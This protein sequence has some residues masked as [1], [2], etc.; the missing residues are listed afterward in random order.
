MKKAEKNLYD[1]LKRHREGEHQHQQ[2]VRPYCWF[3]DFVRLADSCQ[4]IAR[5]EVL[6]DGKRQKIFGSQLVCG[7]IIHLEHADYKIDANDDVK[8]LAQI[9]QELTIA[10]AQRRQNTVLRDLEVIK[11]A[12]P[13]DCLVLEGE[14]FIDLVHI[15][16]ESGVWKRSRRTL[17]NVVATAVLMPRSN[18]WCLVV[19]VGAS[20]SQGMLLKLEEVIRSNH[21][22]IKC[23][24]CYC[25]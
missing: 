10:D 20:S 15:T 3:T 1:H 2:N 22:R 8:E 11:N 4:N 25:C 18:A 13:C 17:P 9:E 21:H 19:G 12:V 14:L 16:G 6:R 24:P 7:D 23:G 5:Y